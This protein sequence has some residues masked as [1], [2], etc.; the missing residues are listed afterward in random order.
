MQHRVKEELNFILVFVGLVWL[1]FLI[2]WMIANRISD[3]G[4]NAWGLAPRDTG[5]LIGVIT[6]PFLHGGWNHLIGNTLPLTVLLCLVAGSR[7][8]TLAVVP[9]VTLCGGLLLWCFGR[10]TGSD[11]SKFIHVGASGLIYGLMTFLIVGGFREQRLRELGIAVFVGIV[12]GGTLL[13]G[14]VP[15]GA[16]K[17]VSWDGHLS[18]AVGGIVAAVVL[19]PRRNRG[20]NP[21]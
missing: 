16:A 19:I 7:A 9:L 6:M 4:L 13:S 5:H 18:G 3:G 12:Y 8:N 1:V 11:G 15:L 17:G 20:R 14:I 21:A 10:S 2:H